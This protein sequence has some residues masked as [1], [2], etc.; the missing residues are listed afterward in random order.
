M[1]QSNSEAHVEE[2]YIARSIRE[3]RVAPTEFCARSRIVF[4]NT[5]A[6]DEYTFRSTETRGTDGLLINGNVKTIGH[7]RGCFGTTSDPA[8]LNLYIEAT[9]AGVN[10]TGIGDCR[11]LKQGFP[12][13]G[14][15]LYRC[16][17]ELRDLSNGYVGGLLTTNTMISGELLGDQSQPPGYTQASVATVRLWMRRPPA[18][19]ANAPR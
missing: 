8:T 13:S 11:T 9:L 3:A 1:A 18:G 2:I 19:Q 12:E 7:A 5:T 17:L 10:F 4:G 16:Y 6:E 14:I 15:T